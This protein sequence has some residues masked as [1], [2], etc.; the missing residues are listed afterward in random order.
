MT[1]LERFLIFYENVG[2]MLK[3]QKNKEGENIFYIIGDSMYAD[4]TEN[5]LDKFDGYNGF[6]SDVE[7]T[8]KGQFV[9]QGFWE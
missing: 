4:C 7:F 2:I 6:F 1:D 3:P 9:R 8:A 5:N